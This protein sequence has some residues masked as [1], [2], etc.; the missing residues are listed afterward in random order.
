MSE[1]NSPSDP[2]PAVPPA[3]SFTYGTPSAP[4][5]APAPVPE[6]AQQPLAPPQYGERLPGYENGPAAGQPA[7]P[8]VPPQPGYAAPAYGSPYG[9]PPVKKR[10]MWDTVLTIILLVIGLFGMI[11]GLFYAWILSDPNLF[12]EAMATQGFTL[13]VDTRGAA[14]IIGVS[15]VVLYLI[16]AGVGILLLIKNKVAFWVPLAAGVI[17]A[18]VFWGT[19]MAAIMSDPSFMNQMY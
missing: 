2:T 16:G 17:A 9:A 1:P 10:R 11:I 14:T 7:A 8:A 19:L 12:R 4:Q 18:I 15:H 13:N 6:Q 3:P 5:A